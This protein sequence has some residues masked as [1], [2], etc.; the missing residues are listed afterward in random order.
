MCDAAT[1]AQV[2]VRQTVDTEV[3]RPMKR[4]GFILASASTAGFLIPGWGRAATPCPP[5]QLSVA[6]G[7]SV[8]TPCGTTGTGQTY[9]TNFP[10]TENPIS[11]GGVWSNVGL[12]WTNVRTTPGLAFGT[13]GAADAYDDSYAHLAGFPAN[14]SAQATIYLD[15]SIIGSG[16]THEVELFLRMS[17]SAHVAWGYECNMDF[18]GS[19]SIIRWNGALGDWT[20]LANF[21][22]FAQPVTGDIFK[23]TIVGNAI[24]LY[25]NGVARGTATDS[26]YASGNPG[27]GFFKRPAGTNNVFGFSS[28]TAAPA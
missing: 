9:T 7:G 3:E 19:L 2:G 8:T 13:N 27:M 1:F 14:Q 24:T 21:G 26:A 15:P 28:Y 25:H 18:G 23:A 17:D 4:R 16:E 10:G 12:D 11:E 5:P 22:S 6:G 20:V